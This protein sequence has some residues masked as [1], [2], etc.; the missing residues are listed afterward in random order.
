[1]ARDFSD[2]EGVRLPSL[3]GTR[4]VVIEESKE[5][6]SVIR[7]FGVKSLFIR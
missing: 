1:M 5:I 7:Y 2:W 4:D 6:K 3:Y